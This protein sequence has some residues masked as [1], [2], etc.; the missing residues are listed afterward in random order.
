MNSIMTV[1]ELLIEAKRLD[2]IS[3]F[4][5]A[6]TSEIA[7]LNFRDERRSEMMYDLALEM[8]DRGIHDE[9]K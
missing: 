8:I 4:R 1:E 3:K 6:E 9:V 5:V 2:D 7:E